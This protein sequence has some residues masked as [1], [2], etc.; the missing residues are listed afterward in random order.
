MFSLALGHTVVIWL[1]TLVLLCII[2]V[3]YSK[4][5]VKELLLRIWA[6]ISVFFYIEFWLVLESI[7]V[8]VKKLYN[9]VNNSFNPC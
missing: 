3:A 1:S 5:G 4:P 7:C 8:A 2:P 6:A 9:Q